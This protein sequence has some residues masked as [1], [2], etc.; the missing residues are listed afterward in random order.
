MLENNLEKV[1]FSSSGEKKTLKI[2][3][4]FPKASDGKPVCIQIQY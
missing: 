1:D 4:E 3:T 2:L